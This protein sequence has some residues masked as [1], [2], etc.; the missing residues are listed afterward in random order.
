MVTEFLTWSA[1][2]IGTAVD[3]LNSM[4]LVPGVTVLGFMAATFILGLLMTDLVV[5]A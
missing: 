5:K 1:T 4:Q 3:W 2:L